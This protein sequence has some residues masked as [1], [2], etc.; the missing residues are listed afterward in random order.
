MTPEEISRLP[1]RPCVGVMVVNAEGL[2]WAGKRIDN[3]GDAWQMPQGGVDKGE[4]VQTA[5]LRELV[6]E[7]SIPADAVTIMGQTDEWVKYD[8][9]HDLVPKLWKGRFRGQKQKW[10]V[11]RF[12]GPD[13][14]IRIDTEHPEF[15]HWA[16]MDYPD[17]LA[18]IV[19]FKTHVYQ[20]VW[21]ALG[22]HV[23]ALRSNSGGRDSPA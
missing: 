2:I 18:K 4:D 20:E 21:N 15:S 1:Y 12:D 6:E 3:P 13:S 5:A 8:L 10:F 9:P 23:E 16:W 7:T 11:L 17:L 14:L 19:P 22:H